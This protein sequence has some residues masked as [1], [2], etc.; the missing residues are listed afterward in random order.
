MNELVVSVL[1]ST[2][3]ENVAVIVVERAT[4]VAPE[5]GDVEVTDSGGGGALVVNVQLTGAASVVPSAAATVPARRA[6][7]CVEYAKGAD[8]VRVAVFEAES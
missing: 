7:Y 1:A 5:A 2:A 8:G 3:R 6:V 4:E